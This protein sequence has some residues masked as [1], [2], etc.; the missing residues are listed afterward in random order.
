MMTFPSAASLDA[1]RDLG[2]PG[3]DFESMKPYYRKFHTFNE[4][5]EEV[6]K[7]LKLDYMDAS[8]HGKE[9]PVQITFGEYQKDFERAWADTFENLG[10]KA[11][12][13]PI[14]GTVVGGHNV[15]ST[16]DPKTMT[17]SYS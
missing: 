5:S 12:S 14:S 3:W 1:W 15:P 11:K 17:R 6:S 7:A 2:N 9:G 16:I 8:L 4:P 10:Y 13:D